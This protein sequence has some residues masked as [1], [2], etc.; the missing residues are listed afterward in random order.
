MSCITQK[1]KQKIIKIQ[2][3]AIRIMTNSA[4]NA[5]TNPLF[6][7]HQILPYDLI[8]KQSQLTFMH[9]VAHN[10]APSSFA[11]TWITNADRDPELNLRNANDFYLP[12]PRTETFKKSTY[13]ALPATWNSLTPY[14]KLQ[15]NK[16]TFKWALKAHLLDEWPE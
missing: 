15:P 3:K 1:N 8:I 2:K 13:Y 9:T 16:I 6:K 14:I 4:Y 7:K 11:N 5:H 10:L 12:Q